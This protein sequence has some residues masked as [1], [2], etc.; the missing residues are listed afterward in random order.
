MK[1][2]FILFILFLVGCTNKSEHSEP[3]IVLNAGV[4][5]VSGT[6]D[7]GQL[8]KNDSK[9]I[10]VKINNIGDQDL[11]GPPIIDN[12]NFSIIYQSGC[13]IIKPEKSCILKISFSSQNKSYQIHTANLNLDT[14]FLQLSGE[15]LNPNPNQTIEASFSVSSLDFGTITD[16]QSS[17]KSVIITNTGNTD[18]E[19][20]VVSVATGNLFNI[21]SDGCSNRKMKPLQK[22]VLRISFIGAGKAGLINE[23]LSFGGASLPISGTVVSYI[24]TSVLGSPDVKLLVNNNIQSSYGLGTIAGTQSKLVTVIAKNLGNKASQMDSAQLANNNFTI[25]FNQCSSK[26]LEPG[27]TC[28]VKIA[29]DAANKSS[30]DY[31]DSLSFQG[32]TVSLSTTVVDFIVNNIGMAQDTKS[33]TITGVGLNKVSTVQILDSNQVEID[34][35]KIDFQN[36]TKIILKPTKN[37][38]LTAGQY[39]FRVL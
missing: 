10:S 23:T 25:M 39:I 29:F 21:V 38:I 16:K 19:N 27:E 2:I 9:I 35:L 13:N 8:G 18:I 20:Q 36:E 4:G 22:C 32:Q 6:G 34:N 14:A 7:F 15:V 11:I 31:T 5:V 30:T 37:L 28:Q 26:I 17:L 3:Q 1:K 12:N 33:F 24:G